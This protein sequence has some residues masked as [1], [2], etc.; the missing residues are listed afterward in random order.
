MRWS[1]SFTINIS[2]LSLVFHSWF[3]FSCLSLCPELHISLL[4]H[5]QKTP[6]RD[7]IKGEREVNEGQDIRKQE[8]RDK[9]DEWD[10]GVKTSTRSICPM[11]RLFSTSRSYHP[12]SFSYLQ[13]ERS[14]SSA[15]ETRNR[16]D[17]HVSW[18]RKK[19]R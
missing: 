2:S 16:A 18:L 13:H 5:I 3:I 12:P 19:K 10:E 17:L 15:N 4:F 9:D 6:G 1:R 7:E 14:E 11:H 8:P